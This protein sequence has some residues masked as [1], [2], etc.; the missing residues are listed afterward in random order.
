MTAF[1][2]PVL[3]HIPPIRGI[4]NE[5]LDLRW[6]TFKMIREIVDEHVT[7]F[8]GVDENSDVI[9]MF[10]DRIVNE[11]G[12]DDDE[13]F[14]Y[15]QLHAFL[16]DIFTAGAETSATTLLWALLY[17]ARYPDLQ[18]ELRSEIVEFIGDSEDTCMSNL[19]KLHLTRAT[20]HEVIRIRPIVTL[21]VPRK[22]ANDCEVMGFKFT[23][24][25]I[26]MPNLWSVHHNEEDFPNPEVFNPR[27]YID[28]SGV[29]TPH[30]HVMGFSLG[31]RRC[32]GKPIAQCSLVC[33]LAQLV[34]NFEFRLPRVW[35]PKTQS[36]ETAPFDFRGTN[37][38]VLFTPEYWLQWREITEE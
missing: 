21:S 32:P 28:E 2:I 7:H 25:T 24:D 13:Y 8:H 14:T 23:K 12:K 31:G 20:I 26:V 27:R 34:K 11:Q 30:S 9:D 18:N 17:L 29:F 15:S 16:F 1:L 38:Q 19:S 10:I 35:N 22:V 33:T 37:E 36:Y 6:A 5:G 3:K 4:I